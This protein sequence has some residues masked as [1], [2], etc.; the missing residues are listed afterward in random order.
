MPSRD[1]VLD[2]IDNDKIKTYMEGI[3][4]QIAY[5]YPMPNM[6]QASLFWTAFESAFANIWNG[7]TTDIQAELDTANKSATKK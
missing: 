5:S 1:D 7:E 4:K 3:N 2:M 6:A